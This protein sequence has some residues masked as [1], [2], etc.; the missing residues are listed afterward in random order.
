MNKSE[1]KLSLVEP[2]IRDRRVLDVGFI[3][4]SAMSEDVGTSLHASIVKLASYCHGLDIQVDKVRTIKKLGYKCTAGNAE[5]LP[6]LMIENNLQSFDVIIAFE[7]IEHLLCQRDFLQGARSALGM[8]GLL[9]LSTPNPWLLKHIVARGIFN[10]KNY[11]CNE[12]VAFLD[13]VMIE[14]LLRRTG[15]S[16]ERIEY[17]PPDSSHILD[18]LAR[19][20][21]RFGFKRF[22]GGA[23]LFIVAGK[24]EN[25]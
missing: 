23:D 14:N 6:F 12:H 18:K 2:Y 15:W 1:R 7:L 24:K 8:N 4:N 20:L 13:E 3:G 5:E 25:K 21:F 11:I 17:L 9:I 10:K 19:I 22:L 16:I